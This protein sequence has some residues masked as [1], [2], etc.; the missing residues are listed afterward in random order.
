M[1][2][3]LLITLKKNYEKEEYPI[4]SMRTIKMEDTD[5]TDINNLKKGGFFIINNPPGSTSK[6]Q[7]CC[8]C[9]NEIPEVDDHSHE[10]I[11]QRVGKVK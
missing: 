7:Y 11:A 8:E 3:I 10:I 6:H 9:V 2:K 4:N 5:I 1:S